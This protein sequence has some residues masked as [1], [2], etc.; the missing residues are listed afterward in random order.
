[1]I[2]L[3]RLQATI[4]YYAAGFFLPAGGQA[5]KLI[6][7]LVGDCDCTKKASA[8]EIFAGVNISH[9]LSD[10]SCV[11]S[12]AEICEQDFAYIKSIGMDHVRI[13]I[14]EQAMWSPH[15]LVVGKSFLKLKKGLDWCM[16][17]SL[18]AVIT[19]K[20]VKGLSA[21]TAPNSTSLLW[22]DLIAQESFIKMW[23]N[24]SDFLKDYPNKMLAYELLSE[25]NAPSA[26]DWA[27]LYQLVCQTIRSREPFRTLIIGSNSKQSEKTIKLISLLENDPNIMLSFKYFRP[28]GLT[29]YGASWLPVGAYS[30][31]VKYPGNI[32]PDDYSDYCPSTSGQSLKH[33]VA[34]EKLLSFWDKNRIQESIS[35]A[36]E[37][38]KK[39][40]AALYC[41]HFGCIETAP[42][43]DK[44]RYFCDIISCFKENGIAFAFWDYKGCFAITKHT[45]NGVFVTDPAV[46]KSMGIINPRNMCESA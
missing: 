36:V 46:K 6:S 29:H 3:P 27:Y 4:A 24:L 25:P 11:Y 22:D 33:L 14:D 2:N 42:H 31:P 17:H 8:F 30:G 38:S 45:Y 9:W 37:H 28:S 39:T 20:G 32:W 18:K 16:K 15:G 44:E 7:F 21:G 10:T 13:P 12:S 34:E 1:V 43:P 41:S 26:N 19:I 35:E 40:G 23:R 5:H